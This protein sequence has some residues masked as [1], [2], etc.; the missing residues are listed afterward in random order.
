M[1]Q[2][3]KGA[4]THGPGSHRIMREAPDT[5]INKVMEALRN[6]SG[7][8][9]GLAGRRRWIRKKTQ[10]SG[11]GLGGQAG[12]SWDCGGQ[13]AGSWGCQ[14]RRDGRPAGNRQRVRKQS[15]LQAVRID[16]QGRFKAHGLP[17]N[18]FWVFD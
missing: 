18:G 13:T 12:G 4:V 16:W 10:G 8:S 11:S 14:G 1:A 9:A 7:G 15:T 2:S 17:Q 3:R 5:L 6:A